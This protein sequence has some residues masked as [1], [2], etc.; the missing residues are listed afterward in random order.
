MKGAKI[1]IYSVIK[2]SC[3]S[4]ALLSSHRGMS[5]CH[6]VHG[7]HPEEYFHCHTDLTSPPRHTCS[8]TIRIT[9]CK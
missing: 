3:L 1:G 8:W 5:T 9:F 7:F 6:A 4:I 2:Q